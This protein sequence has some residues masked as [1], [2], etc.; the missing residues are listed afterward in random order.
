VLAAQF[1][2]LPGFLWIL[3]GVVLG[4]GSRPA[5]PDATDEFS[6]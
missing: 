1:G 2:F 3:F 6:S 4:N 5:D